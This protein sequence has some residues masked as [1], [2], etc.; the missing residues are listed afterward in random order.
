MEEMNFQSKKFQIASESNTK[1]DCY[2]DE[3]GMV[4]M[5]KEFLKKRGFCCTNGCRHCP[6]PKEEEN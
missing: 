3:N 2:T 5:T 6:Y 1:Q 4:V